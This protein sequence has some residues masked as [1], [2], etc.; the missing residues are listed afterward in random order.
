MRFTNKELL[1]FGSRLRRIGG[2]SCVIF[3]T[4]LLISGCGSSYS[5]PFQNVINDSSYGIAASTSL[6]AARGSGFASDLCIVDGDT[7][8]IDPS[9]ADSAAGLLLDLNNRS[10]LFSRN[11]F[12][13]MY[14]ASMTKVMTAIVALKNSSSD[15]V[16]TA[17]D[18]VTDLEYGAQAAGISPGDT[19]T[20]DQALHLL[21][22]Y[23]ANDAAI[24][25]ADSVAGSVDAFTD[26]M[27]EEADALGATG[28][29]FTNANGLQD[30][31]L[32]TTPY[33]MYLI[34]NEA[35]NY[36]LFREIINIQSYDTIIHDS[37]GA[38]KEM[39]YNSTN[40]YLN[41]QKTA[42]TG[43]TI[44]GGK[45]GTTAAAG[46]CLVLLARDS[47]GNPYIGLIMRATDQDTMYNDM[48]AMLNLIGS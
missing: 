10:V 15:T 9:L 24:V 12:T 35:L 36:D 40:L 7:G 38:E 5:I 41:G 1:R 42:P 18:D 34:F 3:V 46:H 16:I 29:H 43:I 48:N 25:I 32:Y 37:S 26:M 47:A 11:A 28:T 8:D 39:H 21:L 17:G 22:I 2:L 33:D 4:A 30:E 20:M 31:N 13:Q 44:V 6:T 23:S 27:N 45:T 19:M 14:P